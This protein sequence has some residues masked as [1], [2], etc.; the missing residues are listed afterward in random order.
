MNMRK[1]LPLVAVSA[2]T[3]MLLVGVTIV[4][5]ALPDISRGL[6][7]SLPDLQWVLSVY[8]L[9][10]A[11]L[12]LT[13]GS[14]AD[15]IGRR[16]VYLGGLGVFAAASLACGLAPNIEVLIAASGFMGLG[17]AAMFATTLA[18]ISSSYE[19]KERGI[20]FGIWAA[21]NGAASAAGPVVGGLLTGHFGWRW[22]FLV[23]LPVTALAVVLTR[24]TVRESRD[25]NP[26]RL[27]LPGM[28]SFTVAAATLVYALIRGSF[29][30]G[31]TLLLLA[32]AAVA[33][34]VFVLVERRPNAMLDLSLLRN[35]SFATL[36]ATA[37]LL[38]AA[39]WAFLAFQTLWLQSVLGL[40]P[41]Q[42][43]LVWLPASATT[44]VVSILVGRVM[45]QTS[46]RL[47]IGAGMALVSAGALAL[48][49]ID[50]GSGWAVLLPGMFVVGLGAG[51]VLG[52]LS[53]AAMAAV[54]GPRAGMAAGAVNTFRQL[55]YAIGIAVLGAVFHR[56]LATTAGPE[57]AGP[58]GSGG[59]KAVMAQG[60]DLANVVH[61]AYA[62]ALDH[63]F[64]VAAAVAAL[65]TIAV[66]AFVRPQRAGSQVIRS[67]TSR[68]PI[69]S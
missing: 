2:G 48:T 67:Q 38:P 35:S 61:Q 34:V 9:V 56:G 13:A 36:L 16:A 44:F 51:L 30:S 46:H 7:A 49:L 28:V 50:A 3:F 47:L 53:A 18:L 64:L 17:A 62:N 41:I 14:L 33:L 24:R 15:R 58:I 4:T 21:V 10:L 19:G 23:N 59:A 42:A 11:A 5:V 25:P 57:L 63:T 37:A 8:A 22:I 39:A 29:G 66:V 55:G 40:S 43:G 69:H 1:W 31:L 20:A 68:S 12:V 32:T 52:P 6:G 26:R 60:S 27:D 65:A 54:P 45:H